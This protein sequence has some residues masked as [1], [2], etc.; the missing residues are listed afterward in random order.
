M[1]KHDSAKPPRLDS[2]VRLRAPLRFWNA[3]GHS[4]DSGGHF[5]RLPKRF[6]LGEVLVTKKQRNSSRKR[7][8]NRK[9]PPHSTHET[10][11]W[12]DA[13]KPGDD[14]KPLNRPAFRTAFAQIRGWYGQAVKRGQRE[15]RKLRLKK[16]R[17]E[18]TQIRKETR[19]AMRATEGR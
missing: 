16:A 5:L 13:V 6:P 7:C 9:R 11:T 15:I 1:E 8:Q 2:V 18:L 3:H 10:E 12:S 19:K 4:G 14:P 17:R